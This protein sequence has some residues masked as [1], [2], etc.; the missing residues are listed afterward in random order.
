ML[1]PRVA[2]GARGAWTIGLQYRDRFAALAPIAGSGTSPALTAALAT[3]K[4]IPL[5]IVAGVKDALVP[6]QGCRA[7]AEQTRKSGWEVKYAEYPGGDHLSVAV[8]SIPEVFQ[9]FDSH[10]ADHRVATGPR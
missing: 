3:G 2:L 5:L 9:W 8:M 1:S 10:P 7:A 4:K 6:V